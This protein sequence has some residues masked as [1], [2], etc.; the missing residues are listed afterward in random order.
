MTSSYSRLKRALSAAW[1][2]P[3]SITNFSGRSRCGWSSS[4]WLPQLE[5]DTCLDYLH[6]KETLGSAGN[7]NWL[8]PPQDCRCNALSRCAQRSH[9]AVDQWPRILRPPGPVHGDARPRFHARGCGRFSSVHPSLA[10]LRPAT[11]SAPPDSLPCIGSGVRHSHVRGACTSRMNAP[12][13]LSLNLAPKQRGTH[14]YYS[15]PSVETPCIHR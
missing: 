11:G 5:S 14:G 1:D 8:L 9:V 13:R 7:I 4:A 2:F 12:I 6:S 3:C 15:A 10:W